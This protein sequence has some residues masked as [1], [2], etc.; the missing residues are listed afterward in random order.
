MHQGELSS[1]TILDDIQVKRLS[2]DK[3]SSQGTFINLLQVVKV[4]IDKL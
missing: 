2:K 4:S 1:N 3:E